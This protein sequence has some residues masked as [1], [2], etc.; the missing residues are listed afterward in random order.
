MESVL[1]GLLSEKG[2]FMKKITSIMLT[3]V[4]TAVMCFGSIGSVYAAPEP[5][6]LED[7]S[8][9]TWA[10]IGQT[11]EKAISGEIDITNTTWSVG[12]TK[13]V[14]LTTGETIQLQIADFNHD[15]FEDGTTA[16]ITLVMKD[17]LNT[18]APMN[19]SSTYGDGGYPDSIMKNYVKEN[20]YDKLPTDLKSIVSP[21]K[22]KS[23]TDCYDENSLTE[24]SYN[25]WL[26]AEAEV[27]DDVGYTIGNGE[28]TKYSIFS[29]D[30]SRIKKVN[31]SATT[32]WLRSTDRTID[33]GAACVGSGGTVADF[34]ATYNCGV[35]VG[36]CVRGTAASEDTKTIDVTV[37]EVIA[38]VADENGDFSSNV[39]IKNNSSTMSVDTVLS[40]EAYGEWSIVPSTTNF[41]SM[42]ANQKK[43]SLIAEESGLSEIDLSAGSYSFNVSKLGDADFVLKGKTGPVTENITEERCVTVGLYL[44]EAA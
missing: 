19:S 38:F 35:A 4:M 25:V 26:L 23:Y 7:F 17:C 8:D 37:P 30:A 3:L 13:D 2:V 34:D 44:S 29:D 40:A 27:V 43:F 42:G 41:A 18:K 24:E 32:W 39:N 9:C 31:G 22:K 5:L 21:V 28:G 20:I 14:T 6:V 1:K 36:M 33:I 12:D 16:P 11:V 10:E 15:T